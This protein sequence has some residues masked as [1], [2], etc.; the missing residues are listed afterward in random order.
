V[1]RLVLIYAFSFFSHKL[2]IIVGQLIAADTYDESVYY[3]K[4]LVNYVWSH[5]TYVVEWNSAVAIAM[6][7][8]CV[9]LD[10]SVERWPCSGREPIERKGRRH[11]PPKAFSTTTTRRAHATV[12]H[13]IAARFFFF[14]CCISSITVKVCDSHVLSLS[15]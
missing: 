14:M 11:P 9:L 5:N 12:T 1:C 4:L 10:V 6:C 13:E 2:I 7:I 3:R 15:A 8:H